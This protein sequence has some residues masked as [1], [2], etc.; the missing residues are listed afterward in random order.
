MNEEKIKVILLE[1]NKLAK[2]TEINNN[3]KSMQK[4]VKGYIE[5][6]S[7]FTDNTCFIVNEEGKNNNLPLNRAIYDDN[8]NMIEI[9]AGT[10]FICGNGSTEKFESLSEEQINYYMKQFKYPEKFFRIND[11]IKAIPYN[12]QHEL[13]R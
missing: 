11:E 13:E 2:I 5:V 6:Y 4:I 3:L 9:I 10:A 8:K 7:P 12:P 1:P